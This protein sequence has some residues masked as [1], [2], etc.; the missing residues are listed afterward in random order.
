MKYLG[1][2]RAM[3]CISMQSLN[4]VKITFLSKLMCELIMEQNALKKESASI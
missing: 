3:P 1:K 2:Q 4:N